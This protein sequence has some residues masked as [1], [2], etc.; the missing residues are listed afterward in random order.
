MPAPRS[1]RDGFPSIETYLRMSPTSIPSDTDHKRAHAREDVFQLFDVPSFPRRSS[2]LWEDRYQFNQPIKA[3]TEADVARRVLMAF[4]DVIREAGMQ[5]QLH[6][7][8]EL[9]KV[10][11]DIFIVSLAGVVL[12]VV[13]VKKPGVDAMTHPNIVGEVFDQL[14]HLRTVFGVREAFGVLTSYKQWRV[15]W[16]QDCQEAAAA[17]EPT[18]A[19]ALFTTPTKHGHDNTQTPSPPAVTPSKRADSHDCQMDAVAIDESSHEED[20]SE[21]DLCC[22][23]VFTQEENDDG[24]L[25]SFLYTVLRKMELSTFLEIDL[26]QKPLQRAVRILASEVAEWKF[27]TLIHGLQWDRYPRQDASRFCVWDDLG[28]G[29]S[30][31]ALLVSSLSGAVCVLKFFF[32]GS[33]DDELRWWQICYPQFQVRKIR[34]L[35]ADALQMP[36][37][38]VAP[39]TE[40]TL[41]L[42][43]QCL[44]TRFSSRGIIHKDVRWRNLGTVTLDHVTSVV[45]YDLGDVC[46]MNDEDVDW[47]EKAITSLRRSIG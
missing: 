29:G 9:Q 12:G 42:V 3:A 47:V 17:V 7:E 15:F 37:F 22:S 41:A 16:L 40:Q 25:Y 5:L 27:V 32:V 11:P 10:R 30:G 44:I 45:V 31:R 6:L 2:R 4:E 24:R 36:H 38:A 23:K 43:K 39:R 34:V 1:V 14:T 18:R 46:G 20:I 33:P 21:R 28:H 35:G 26:F 19:A 13:E 8:V